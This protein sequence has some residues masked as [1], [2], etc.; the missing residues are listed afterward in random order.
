MDQENPFSYNHYGSVFDQCLT[1]S[2]PAS[3]TYSMTIGT[4][5]DSIAVEWHNPPA[6][7]R[8]PF[9]IATSAET[10]PNTP[11]DL[12]LLGE[13]PEGESLT[14]TVL[15][16]GQLHGTLTGSGSQ[17]KYTPAS[18]YEGPAEFT[19]RVNDGEFDSGE[20]SFVIWVGADASDPDLPVIATIGRADPYRQPVPDSLAG[21]DIVDVAGGGQPGSFA[22]EADGDIHAWGGYD[23]ISGPPA[24]EVEKYWK[25]P[26]AL[27]S[28]NVTAIASDGNGYNLAVDDNDL[29]TA[30]GICG[31]DIPNA[32]QGEPV[33]KV[34]TDLGV[35]IA[36]LPSGQVL[37]WSRSW[38]DPEDGDPTT[39][40]ALHL[41]EPHDWLVGELFDDVAS[42]GY[43]HIGL[44][45]DGR[46]VTWENSNVGWIADIDFPS[47]E[48]ASISGS[49]R[50]MAMVT[51]DG[52]LIT[53]NWGLTGTHNS[54]GTVRLTSEDVVRSEIGFSG[55]FMAVTTDGDLRTD[56]RYEQ[57]GSH[58]YPGSYTGGLPQAALG[59]RVTDVSSAQLGALALA[60]L[61]D[62]RRLSGASRYETAVAISKDG[63]GPNVP[64]VYIATGTNFPDALSAGPAAAH[65]G[66]PLLLVAATNIPTAVKQ[67][68]TRLNPQRIVVVGGTGAVSHAIYNQLAAY[69]D[70]GDI[71]RDAG[72]NRYETSRVV[73]DRAF[74]EST[75]VYT[76]TG[77][78]FPDALSAS[79]AAA[80]TDSAVLLLPGDSSSV[81]A[82]A[83]TLLADLQTDQVLIAGGT[84]V[85]SPALA[86][87]LN[88]LPGI[89]SV[90]RLAGG[91]RY[92]TSVAVNR[93]AFAES[94]TV[95]LATGLSFADALPGG[96]LAARY[97]APLYVTPSHCVPGDVL[98]DIRDFR[99]IDIVLLGGT[100]ALATP[101][102]NLSRC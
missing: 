74:A 77:A 92:A 64:V 90:I 102:A 79:A 15:S 26:A 86:A 80:H 14:Y 97:D 56:L 13:D 29:V 72:S 65:L 82:A 40:C 69:V 51:T 57:G 12:T 55:A 101:V 88:A 23:W 37:P 52:K 76:A 59:R 84:G 68:L 41:E 66:G 32:L 28:K 81:P 63:F 44:T 60:P 5:T 19:Y 94:S 78:N 38:Y 6:G 21:L 18:G 39:N 45:D 98:D 46:V 58:Y 11:I 75:I 67:E 61:P 1:V 43:G 34:D 31:N 47:V 33:T 2:E 53:W 70:P 4:A 99:A 93:H 49:G 91:N 27:A 96:P 100:G 9:A 30:W 95:F 3:I 73:V 36:L 20:A 48:I 54:E 83:K 35:G 50:E 25:V 7:N 8:K 16:T 10:L 71:R 24:S 17:R 85:V 89:D 42:G 22:L 62:V 87:S